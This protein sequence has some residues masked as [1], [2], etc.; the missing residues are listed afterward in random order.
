MS[1]KQLDPK[2][3][4]PYSTVRSASNLQDD[5]SCQAVGVSRSD[6]T[7]SQGPQHQESDPKVKQIYSHVQIQRY[8]SNAMANYKKFQHTNKAISQSNAG[9]PGYFQQN[10]NQR[11]LANI[12]DKSKLAQNNRS[13]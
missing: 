6:N 10:S 5:K 8:Q 12:I 3:A 2:L 4:Q 1:E 9:G 13:R 7:A 11:S